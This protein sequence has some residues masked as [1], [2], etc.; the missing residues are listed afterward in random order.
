MKPIC[1]KSVR[2]NIL[3]ACH[4]WYSNGLKHETLSPLLFFQF[5]SRMQHEEGAGEAAETEIEC[6][7][8]FSYWSMWGQHKYSTD[9]SDKV[10]DAIAASA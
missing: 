2:A 8:H 6:D 10:R 7:R 3:N 9:A 4:I 5:R 1:S